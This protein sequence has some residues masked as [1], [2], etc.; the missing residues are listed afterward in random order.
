MQPA[1]NQRE[2]DDK[3]LRTLALCHGISAFLHVFF[4]A[5]CAAYPALLDW[6]LSQGPPN[7]QTMPSEQVDLAKNMM[8]AYAVVA[9][10]IALAQVFGC[11]LIAGRRARVACIVIG[12][13]E[14]LAIPLGTILGVFTIITL[15]K[16]S[17]IEIFESRK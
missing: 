9:F 13:I 12:C 16:P 4:G 2:I 10:A 1:W 17:V 15:V 6:L 5:C 8:I 3:H 7:Q 14:L 11:G